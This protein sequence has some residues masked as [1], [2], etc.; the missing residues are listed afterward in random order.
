MDGELLRWLYHYLLGHGKAA[1]T[2]RC[3]YDEGL[4]VLI[5]LQAVLCNR[6]LRWA[7]S[8]QNWPIWCRRVLTFPSYSQ[9]RR[10]L[11]KPSAAR[12]VLELDRHLKTRLGCSDQKVADGK[13]LTIGGFSKDRDATRGHVPGGFARGY[14]LHA[15]RDAITGVIDVSAVTGL[16][17]GEATVLRPMLRKM[18]LRGCVIRA[19]ANYDSNALYAAAA[20]RRGRLIAPRRKPGR[21]LGHGQHHRHRLL[22]IAELE[23]DP[24]HRRDHAR[25]RSVAERTFADLGNRVGLFGLPNF[26]RRKHRVRKWVRAKIVLYHLIL[27]LGKT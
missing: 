23:S 27:L 3:R 7:A 2:P 8:R 12:R 9:L 20:L 14:R 18:R 6:S 11:L 16:A 26:V 10:R 19:D 5:G 17:A 13:P 25:R 15:V 24:A 22:A 21:G 4:I 1:A